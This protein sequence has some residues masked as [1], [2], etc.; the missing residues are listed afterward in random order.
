MKIKNIGYVLYALNKHVTLYKETIMDKHF[1]TKNT[2]IM[3]Y[4]PGKSYFFEIGKQDKDG[5]A[6]QV[7][8]T[9][10]DGT[11][12]LMFRGGNT[13]LNKKFSRIPYELN[14]FY[15]LAVE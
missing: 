8:D 5:F 12:Y 11:V 6:L 14:E 9:Y 13:I 1:D 7:I 4:V 15:E 3:L 10:D 2:Q